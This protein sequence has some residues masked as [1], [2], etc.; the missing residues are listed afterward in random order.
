MQTFTIITITLNR[1][2]LWKCCHI[3]NTAFY[4]HDSGTCC[5]RG[6]WALLPMC[7]QQA[8]S[9]TIAP[10]TTIPTI[11]QWRIFFSAC[12]LET[13]CPRHQAVLT[14]PGESHPWQ[15][16]HP[17][18]S[19]YPCL[20]NRLIVIT[21]VILTMLCQ[22]DVGWPKSIDEYYGEVFGVAVVAGYVLIIDHHSLWPWYVPPSP[23]LSSFQL[24]WTILVWTL[25]CG[26][27]W[28]QSL[29]LLWRTPTVSLST[30][31]FLFPTVTC[32]QRRWLVMLYFE[33]PFR[34]VLRWWMMMTVWAA[35]GM[36][37]QRPFKHKCVQSSRMASSN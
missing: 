19:L 3:G 26:T 32:L 15:A 5:C 8:P 12:P 31:G 35:G 27:F 1:V 11:W 25:V 22:D 17:H 18:Y 7:S 36:S 23:F 20:L 9:C 14:T 21:W 24:V 10:W 28:T 6:G 2:Y 34:F 13:S 30:L 29:L 16:Q 4:V 33:S 37:R